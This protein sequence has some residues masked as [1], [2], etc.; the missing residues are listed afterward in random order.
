MKFVIET[1]Q[2]NKLPY[3]DTQVQIKNN[4]LFTKI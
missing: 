4:K 1:F 2:K 3:L